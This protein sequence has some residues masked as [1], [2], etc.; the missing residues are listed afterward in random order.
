VT[1]D[2]LLAR[3]RPLLASGD[4]ALIAQGQELLAVLGTPE[5]FERLCEGIEVSEAGRLSSSRASLLSGQRPDPTR[6]GLALWL[7]RRAGRLDGVT[8]LE[9][10]GCDR[11]GFSSVEG[12]PALAELMLHR[13]EWHLDLSPLLSLPA[14]TSL[15]IT[16]DSFDLSALR[17]HPRLQSLSMGGCGAPAN[18]A[19]LPA[20]RTLSLRLPRGMTPDALPPLPGLTELTLAGELAELSWLHRFPRLTRLSIHSHGKADIK[21]LEPLARLTALTALSVRNDRQS[22]PLDLTPLAG[23]TGLVSLDL[24]ARH[25]LDLTPLHALPRL[26]ALSLFRESRHGAEPAQALYRALRPMS[27]LLDGVGLDQTGEPSRDG[28][29]MSPQAQLFALHVQ[30]PP[31]QPHPLADVQRLTLSGFDGFLLDLTPLA[32]LRLLRVLKVTGWGRFDL[33]PLALL[34]GL[35]YV[36]GRVMA[37]GRDEV[38]RAQRRLASD[39]LRRTRL[40]R[41]ARDEAWLERLRALGHVGSRRRREQPA[42]LSRLLASNRIADVI[43][44]FEALSEVGDERII[45]HFAQGVSLQTDGQLVLTHAASRAPHLRR[46]DSMAFTA[47]MALRVAGRLEDAEHISLG[48]NQP[49]YGLEPLEG[50]PRLSRIVLRGGGRLDD[51]TPL[52]TML[53]LR[54][55]DLTRCMRLPVAQR[56]V[57]ERLDLEALLSA[58]RE[59][60]Q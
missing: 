26:R 5:V 29:A 35:E 57:F 23:L 27:R 58:L 55:V 51:L 28:L 8:R 33:T 10:T 49:L 18:L 17:G 39:F 44:G 20:L 36:E 6:T 13:E 40:H 19:S 60:D 16:S 43:A 50:L 21:S 4:P 38:I 45:Q 47:L 2:Q 24:P 30:P 11:A 1:P 31:G 37:S 7:L 52:C 59:R 15:S 56:R 25:D 54:H 42:G 46:R 48:P 34:P 3:I 32:D 22:S 12:L 9:L 53:S 14:L 41:T